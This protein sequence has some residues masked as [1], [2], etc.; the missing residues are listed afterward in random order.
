MCLEFACRGGSIRTANDPAEWRT[1]LFAA[2]TRAVYVAPRIEET[3]VRAAG[4]RGLLKHYSSI[5]ASAAAVRDDGR[6]LRGAVT[7][8]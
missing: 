8:A 3:N 4:G 7:Y 2:S 5:S 6:G 1:L